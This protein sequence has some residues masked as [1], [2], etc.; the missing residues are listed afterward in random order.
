M[1][2]EVKITVSEDD[3]SMSYTHTI[4]NFWPGREDV[5]FMDMLDEAVGEMVKMLEGVGRG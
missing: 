2:R 1:R 5:P 3:R 4:D